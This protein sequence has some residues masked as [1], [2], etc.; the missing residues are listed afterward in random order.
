MNIKGCLKVVAKNKT[1]MRKLLI[2][3]I[4]HRH[5]T[6]E[7][8]FEEAHRQI[9]VLFDVSHRA[10]L[11]WVQFNFQPSP[12]EGVWIDHHNQEE[13]NKEYDSL[14]LYKMYFSSLYGG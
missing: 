12:Q 8:D 6:G 11:D 3:Q 10:F 4:M 7:I 5:K 13:P 14:T 9:C 1:H 2:E